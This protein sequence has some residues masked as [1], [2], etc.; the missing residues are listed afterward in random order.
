LEFKIPLLSF[1]TTQIQPSQSIE[2]EAFWAWLM[3]V[4]IEGVP[5]KLTLDRKG[6]YLML[7]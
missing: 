1:F 3:M 4:E 5:N 6:K 7:W 2:G